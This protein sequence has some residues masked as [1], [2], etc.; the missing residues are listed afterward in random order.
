MGKINLPPDQYF[1][2]YL[3]SLVNCILVQAIESGC[4]NP[5]H[6]PPSHEGDAVSVNPPGGGASR[7]GR[8]VWC[9]R[10]WSGADG[11]ADPVADLDVTMDS[12]DQGWAKPRQN[13]MAAVASV[14]SR[15]GSSGVSGFLER[16]QRW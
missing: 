12:S 6:S 11:R 4:P 16:W 7:R 2:K 10:R 8:H 14:T 9:R 5:L 3:S 13:P 15:G 1:Q